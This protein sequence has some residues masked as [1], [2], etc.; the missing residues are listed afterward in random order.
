LDAFADLAFKTIRKTA[1]V[2]RDID[3]MGALERARAAKAG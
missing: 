2:V 1:E 3:G